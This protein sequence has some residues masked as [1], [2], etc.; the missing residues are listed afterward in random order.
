MVHGNLN[1][2]LC[3]KATISSRGPTYVGATPDAAS[4]LEYLLALVLEKLRV[5]TL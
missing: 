4:P 1:R 2:A 5:R 3:A